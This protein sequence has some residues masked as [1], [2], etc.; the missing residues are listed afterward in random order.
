MNNTLT[1]EMIGL[2]KISP[3]Q[4][5]CYE[6]CPKLFY[7][8]NWL[9]LQLTQDKMHMDFGT[10]IHHAIEY[11]FV[12]YDNNFGG[13]WMAAD[14]QKV[15]DAFCAKW[16]QYQVSDIS[17]TNFMNTR[18]G[19]ESGFTSKEELYNHMRED[20]LAMLKSYWDEKE[21][22]LVEYE[23]DF[24]EFEIPLKVEMVNPTDPEDKLPI[25][26]SMRIDA[27]NRNRTK[28]VDFK[29]SGSKYDEAEA[30]KKI[31]GQCYVFG[32]L[33]A[34]GKFIGKFDYIILRK[35]L[36]STNRI[37]VVQLEYDEADMLSFFERVRSVLVKISNREFSR[38]VV[39]HQNWCDCYKYEEALLV[40]K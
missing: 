15:E 25:P 3:S 20:G 17:F 4:L 29:T 9:G 23:H 33:M 14:F 12:Q 8:Q 21:R 35:N 1:K 37:E 32:Q 38:P 30:R 24:T 34:I 31:Q 2:E 19:K 10:A 11:I 16:R 22:L 40:E 6:Q 18:A 5:D 36:K 39:G 13:A 7:Y 28:T 26:L 27:V